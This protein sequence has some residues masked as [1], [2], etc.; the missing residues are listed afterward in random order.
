MAIATFSSLNMK[1]TEPVNRLLAEAISS[2][3]T[4]LPGRE[5]F[6]KK[7]FYLSFCE[8]YTYYALYSL[9]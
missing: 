2:P 6:S 5:K 7:S 4:S 3:L 8:T 1:S 9:L